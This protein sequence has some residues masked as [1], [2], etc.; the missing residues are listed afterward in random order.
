M[1]ECRRTTDRLA[2]Y[3]DDLLPPAER[4]EVERHCSRCAPCRE[5]AATEQAA[6]TILRNRAATLRN[7]ALP[8]GFR[9]RLEALAREH[10][11][12]VPSPWRRRL[13]PLSLTAGLALVAVVAV[14]WLAAQRSN[15]L[16]AA[17]LTA[18]HA[19]CVREVGGP[20]AES[21]DAPRL[22]SLLS[23]QYGWDVH[24]PPSSAAV[25]VELIGARRCL[26]VPHV[27]YRIGDQ[28]V[29]LYMMEGVTRGEA[30]V[31]TLGYRSRVWSR[32]ATTFVLVSS[33]DAGELETAVAYL[34]QEAY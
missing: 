4:A 7:P 10:T 5:A 30:D 3:V 28:D 26:A 31:E 1:S 19:K 23:E 14:F 24:V 2:A 11:A 33:A 6:R 15:T 32:G 21:A 25:G 27:V 34:K 18:D 22:E 20:E 9:T 13:V 16:F 29:S 12:G 8:P 17:Q